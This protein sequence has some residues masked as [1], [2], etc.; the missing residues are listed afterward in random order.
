[1]TKLDQDIEA[2]TKELAAL[3]APMFVKVNKALAFGVKISKAAEKRLNNNYVDKQKSE[4]SGPPPKSTKESFR[5][6]R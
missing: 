1:M 2:L 3:T 6:P 4:E 5:V